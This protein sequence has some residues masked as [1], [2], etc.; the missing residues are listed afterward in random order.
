MWR[1]YGGGYACVIS[2]IARRGYVQK[3]RGKLS[4]NREGNED[5]TKIAPFGRVKVLLVYSIRYRSI[6]YTNTRVYYTYIVINMNPRN[7]LAF[8]NN[9]MSFDGT[10]LV[11]R[12]HGVT[13][14]YNATCRWTSPTPQKLQLVNRIVRVQRDERKNWK[15][16]KNPKSTVFPGQT[17]V[18]FWRLLYYCKG[19][20]LY[21]LNFTT[22]CYGLP[23]K[24][25]GYKYNRVGLGNISHSFAVRRETCSYTS[26]YKLKTSYNKSLRSIMIRIRLQ[27]DRHGMNP[28]FRRFLIYDRRIRHVRTSL[29]SSAKIMRECE[30]TAS[31][32]RVTW[33][34]RTRSNSRKSTEH[35][36]KSN[37]STRARP[38]KLYNNTFS[39]SAQPITYD[40]QSDGVFYGHLPITKNMF[41]KWKKKTKIKNEFLPCVWHII[42]G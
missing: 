41:R 35:V 40:D 17:I 6:V 18:V 13:R 28:K 4:D 27:T 14:E 21:F 2:A 39:R 38:R 23:I 34:V 36:K 1:G 26:Y 10:P 16:K 7:G 42:Y 25:I 11:G 5:K 29:W 3:R 12:S 31:P 22:L 24:R 20:I 32:T 37:V 15:I 33:H 8:Q 9:R 30:T 19:S